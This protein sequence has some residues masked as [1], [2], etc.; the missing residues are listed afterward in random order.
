M[1]L[2]N[3]TKA[4]IIAKFRE[5]FPHEPAPDFSSGVWT[6]ISPRSGVTTGSCCYL[7]NSQHFCLDGVTEVECEKLFGSFSLMTCADRTDCHD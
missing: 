7:V 1:A 3:W 4:D 2:K 6:E 5:L